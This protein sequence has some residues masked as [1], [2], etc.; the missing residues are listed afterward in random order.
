MRRYSRARLP[1]WGR[2]RCPGAYREGGGRGGVVIAVTESP[3]AE[4]IPLL[5]VGAGH[6][7]IHTELDDAWSSVLRDGQF[8]GGPVVE[9]FEA[10]FAEYCEAAHCVG[11]AN[12]TDALEM[13]LAALDIGPA[14]KSS[15]LRTPS[16]AQSRR[17]ARW[18]RTR[19][20]RCPP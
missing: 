11:V 9:R 7:E 5:D 2:N 18:E 1:G 14:T 15:C 17:S 6:R 16:S 13:I 8:V 4:S 3:P 12:G 20:R 10:G 19:H